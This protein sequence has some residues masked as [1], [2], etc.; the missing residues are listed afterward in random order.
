MGTKLYNTFSSAIPFSYDLVE[1]N[2]QCLSEV[3]QNCYFSALGH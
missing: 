2:A 1:V 3:L